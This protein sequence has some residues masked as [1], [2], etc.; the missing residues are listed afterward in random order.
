MELSEGTI[1]VK[2]SDWGGGQYKNR[3]GYM[4]IIAMNE[5]YYLRQFMIQERKNTIRTH[6]QIE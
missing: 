1:I 5:N 4:K 2:I 3:L 6:I